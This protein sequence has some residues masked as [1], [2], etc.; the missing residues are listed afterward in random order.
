MG[1]SNAQAAGTSPC[2]RGGLT[3]AAR[4]VTPNTG[5]CACKRTWHYDQVCGPLPCWQSPGQAVSSGHS[6]KL[7]L[8]SCGFL[9]VNSA[10]VGEPCKRCRAQQGLY[11][12]DASGWR[13]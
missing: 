4:E 2:P 12:V 10:S 6:R 13:N 11:E 3:S 5:Q 8:A 9:H 7:R 1:D